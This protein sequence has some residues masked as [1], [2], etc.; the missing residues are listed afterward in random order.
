MASENFNTEL[1]VKCA[2]G[3]MA[4]QSD[5]HTDGDGKETTQPKHQGV[6][7]AK[8][9]PILTKGLQEAVARIEVL[10]TKVAA[11]EGG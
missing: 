7:Y 4:V 9:T 2:S 11:L 5:G 8:L 10:E 3:A 6:D 1:N